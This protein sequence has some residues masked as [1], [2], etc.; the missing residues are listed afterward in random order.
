MNGAL[1]SKYPYPVALRKAFLDTLD[2][3]LSFYII[4]ILIPPL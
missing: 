1:T 4:D 3:T 2:P